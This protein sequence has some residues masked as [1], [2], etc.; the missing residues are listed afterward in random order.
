MNKIKFILGCLTLFFASE[1]GAQSL[2]A[3]DIEMDAKGEATLVISFESP[4]LPASGQFDLILPE[5][6]SLKV[7]SKTGKV[8]GTKKGAAFA[9]LED[10]DDTH[11]I[12]I[13]AKEGGDYFFLAYDPDGGEYQATSGQLMTLQVVAS[14][15]A[16]ETN[17]C[18]LK[19]IKFVDLDAKTVGTFTDSSFTITVNGGVPTGINSLNAEENGGAAFNLAGQKVDKN[20][21]GIV[22]KDGKK[23]IVK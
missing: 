7:N 6:L 3:S 14:E 23:V 13:T 8:T 5:G 20:Y 16:F 4:V 12:N 10:E 15:T 17:T 1:V 21:K 18:E 19:N 22:V 2:T 9:D 11:I